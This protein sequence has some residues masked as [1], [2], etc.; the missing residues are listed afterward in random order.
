MKG[1]EMKSAAAHAMQT[2]MCSVGNES[3][4]SSPGV[5]GETSAGVAL[6]S[7][8]DTVIK[9]A[10]GAP[11]KHSVGTDEKPVCAFC[12]EGEDSD[13]ADEDPVIDTKHTAGGRKIFAH[14][15]CLDWTG[16]IWQD[17]EYNWVNVSK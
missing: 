17:D 14:E 2:S 12:D 11:E 6:P 4:T 10:A 13:D 5:T 1:C 7:A 9:A 8:S 16:D 3:G 15:L